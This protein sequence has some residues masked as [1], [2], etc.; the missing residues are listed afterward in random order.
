MFLPSLV[1]PDMRTDPSFDDELISF[2]G[3]RRDAVGDLVEN[4]EPHAIDD[5]ASVTDLLVRLSVVISS[6][7]NRT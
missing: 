6:Q 1:D 2:A 7:T 5:L 3:L 4:Q